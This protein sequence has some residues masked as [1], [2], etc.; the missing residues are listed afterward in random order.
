MVNTGLGDRWVDNNTLAGLESL[1][2]Q[3]LNWNLLNNEW[4]NVWLE[5]T[6]SETHD[7][8]AEDENTHGGIWLGDDWW[9]GRDNQN[10]VTDN[11]DGD[12]DT[13]GLVATPVLISHV[14]GEEWNGV[15]PERVE[16]VDGGSDSWSLSKSTGDT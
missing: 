9:D 14:C 16:G 11:G 7:N 15:N 3:G 10:N 4:R 2:D 8:D 6:G 5:T 1:D 12:R 13:D